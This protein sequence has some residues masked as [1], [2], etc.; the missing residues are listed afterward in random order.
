MKLTRQEIVEKSE[1]TRQENIKIR[2]E[3]YPLRLALQD[4][5]IR[6]NQAIRDGAKPILYKEIGSFR[7]QAFT[8]TGVD[9][10]H[11]YQTLDRRQFGGC[12]DVE[13]ADLLEQ[14]GVERNPI[15]V[16]YTERR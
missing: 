8:V 1:S 3:S 4:E 10:C 2:E 13:W 15:L 14:A 7:A 9:H 5:R 11:Y 16:N 12:N 6:F